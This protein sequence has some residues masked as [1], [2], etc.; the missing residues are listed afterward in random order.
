VAEVVTDERVFVP[1]TAV[2]PEAAVP[3]AAVPEVAVPEV[4]VIVI[5][6]LGEVDE[7]DREVVIGG[8]RAER[9]LTSKLSILTLHG[10][11]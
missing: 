2:V 6:V 3:E 5:D 10:L 11:T 9:L 1:V 8:N 7:D 4:A